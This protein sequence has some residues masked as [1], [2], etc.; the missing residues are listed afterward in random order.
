MHLVLAFLPFS[1]FILASTFYNLFGRRSEIVTIGFKS[2]SNQAQA[3]AQ[4]KAQ[5]RA[6]RYFHF[7]IF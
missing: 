1:I 2:L 4:A 3:Q 6:R 7:F 5:A